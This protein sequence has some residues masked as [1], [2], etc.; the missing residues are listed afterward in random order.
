M[1][2]EKNLI[3]FTSEQSREEAVENGRKGGIASGQ[4]RRYKKML[5]ECLEELLSREITNKNGVT[6]TGAEAIAAKLFQKALN[7][8][9]K[10][11]EVIRDTSGQ[12]PVEKIAHAEI[13]PAVLEKVE[14]IVKETTDTNDDARTSN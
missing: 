8:D 1:A 4:A 3:P 11:F 6:M 13:D 5:R 14:R 10:A 9:T 7:G 12:K 2:N